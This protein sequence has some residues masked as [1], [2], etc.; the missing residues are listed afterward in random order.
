[1]GYS[2]AMA[3]MPSANLSEA[4]VTI[5]V[6]DVVGSTAL[7]VVRGDAEGSALIEACNAAVRAQVSAHNG[8]VVDSVG[9]G[10]MAAFVSPRRAV[11]CALAIRRE[12]ARDA[13]SS[14]DLA[15]GLRI[16]LH[17]GDVLIDGDNLRGA[18]V[19]A[20]SRV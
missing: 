16:G 7:Q 5:L 3:G 8:R 6:T 4:P 10:V 14:P 12:L 9:D 15:V 20:A 19:S 1:M 2:G 18:A 17:T 11:A 13:A